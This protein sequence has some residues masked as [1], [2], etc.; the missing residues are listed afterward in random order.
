MASKLS[1]PGRRILEKLGDGNPVQVPEDDEAQLAAAAELRDQGLVELES[2][3][4]A[5]GGTDQMV[6]ITERGREALGGPSKDSPGRGAAAR[7]ASRRRP[8]SR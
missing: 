6:R 7:Q 4:S 3:V 8:G 5:T 1:D 2:I